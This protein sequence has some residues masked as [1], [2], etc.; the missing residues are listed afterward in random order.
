MSRK[1]KCEE[2][3]DDL[4]EDSGSGSDCSLEVSK[5]CGIIHRPRNSF[6]RRSA[7]PTTIAVACKVETKN[8]KNDLDTSQ[9]N[10]TGFRHDSIFI[11]DL[12]SP[13]HKG[14]GNPNS[15]AIL[16]NDLRMIC[17]ANHPE[18]EKEMSARFYR[19]RGIDVSLDLDDLLSG[20]YLSRLSGRARSVTLPAIIPDISSRNSMCSFHPEVARIFEHEIHKRLLLECPED[21]MPPP[22]YERD[23]LVQP[24]TGSEGGRAHAYNF[25]SI[26]RPSRTAS[27]LKQERA[28]RSTSTAPGFHWQQLL[29]PSH[30]T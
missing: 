20:T 4:D 7:A 29:A 13:L 2:A 8:S 3:Q 18:V 17:E 19:N 16:V 27:E 6:S 22:F 15:D 12:P 23:E 21:D 28:T 30:R 5:T 10:T 26:L 9:D 1:A 11:R 14:R 24:R 25:D